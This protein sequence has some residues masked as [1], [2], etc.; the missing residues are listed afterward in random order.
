VVVVIEPGIGEL[1]RLVRLE[2]AERH[3]G[4][5]P[6]LPHALDHLDD[7]GH[8]AI[9]GVAPR[10]A[11]AEA[12]AARVPGL[13]RRLQHGAH[14]HQLGRLEL[15]IRA[16][17]LAA[18]AAILGAAAGLDRQE[19]AQLHLARG[20]MRAVHGLRL[21]HQFI[22]RQIEQRGDF[23]ARPVGAYVLPSRLREGSGQRAARGQALP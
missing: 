19:R 14:V 5:Q 13:R 23:G 21:E 16:H 12:L 2:H 1:L 20:M 18:I 3:A 8:V 17:R 10:S 11:H 9:L 4:F 15:G 7:R 6:H 22:E